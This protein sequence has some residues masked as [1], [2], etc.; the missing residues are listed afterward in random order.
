MRRSTR[1]LVLAAAVVACHESLVVLPPPVPVATLTVSPPMD[2]VTAGD[3]V[4]LTATAR[5]SAGHVIASATVTWTSDSLQFASVTSTGLVRT[6]FPGFAPIIAAAGDKAD[7]AAIAV[8]PVQLQAPIAGGHHTCALTNGA[9][10]YCWGRNLYG[11]LGAGFISF[12][13]ETPRAVTG[14]PRFT[15]LAAGENHSCALKS[16]GAAFCWGNNAGSQLGSS[17]GPSANP[18]PTAV[19]GGHAFRAL[20][21]GDRH[22][23]GIG[24]DSLTYC[25][26]ANDAGQLGDSLPG[27][28][29]PTPVLV[30]TRRRYVAL[31]AGGVHTCGVNALVVYCWGGNASG[32]L[33]DSTDSTRRAP[34][35]VRDAV[36]WLDV[37]AGTNHTCGRA[38]DHSARCWGKNDHGQLGTG[39]AD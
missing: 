31:A 33:G 15:T 20:V 29:G 23:C 16:N 13:E 39:Q 5:D 32:E 25:W 36:E 7:T 37:T 17:G 8:A 14:I 1:A 3:S 22:T 19:T 28:G 35:P 26:G 12:F 34:V 6:T 24:T 9:A 4:Q 38:L 30:A 27:S 10:T 21:A 11:E 18:V 2:T